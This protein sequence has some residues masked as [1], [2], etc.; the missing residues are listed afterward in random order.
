MATT[1]QPFATQPVAVNGVATCSG[2]G[3][4]VDGKQCMF[5]FIYEGTEYASCAAVNH[6]TPWCATSYYDG[7]SEVREWSNCKCGSTV[8]TQALSNGITSTSVTTT[9]SSATDATPTVPNAD[10]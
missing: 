7:T 3:G 1:A 8:T 10:A 9:L 2:L 5:P 6:A 4:T